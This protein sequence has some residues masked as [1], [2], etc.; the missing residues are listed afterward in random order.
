MNTSSLHSYFRRIADMYQKISFHEMV[1]QNEFRK[2]VMDC[3]I[4]MSC[5]VILNES[6]RFRHRLVI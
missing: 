6:G 4:G 1:Q 5:L 2:L 3:N